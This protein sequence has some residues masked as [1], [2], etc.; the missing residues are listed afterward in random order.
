MIDELVMEM[1]GCCGKGQK[2]KDKC[3]NY[4]P[5]KKCDGSGKCYDPNKQKPTT[6]YEVYRP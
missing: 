1:S 3:P 4:D 5:N 2:D 6:K